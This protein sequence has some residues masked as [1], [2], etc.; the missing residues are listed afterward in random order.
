MPSQ[1]LPGLYVQCIKVCMT[2]QSCCPQASGTSQQQSHH[3]QSCRTVSVYRL[4]C[5]TVQGEVWPCCACRQTPWSVTHR[6]SL[7]HVTG[8]RYDKMYLLHCVH[9]LSSPWLPAWKRHPWWCWEEDTVF[10]LPGPPQSPAEQEPVSKQRKSRYYQRAQ[11]IEKDAYRLWTVCVN[12]Y[13]CCSEEYF[14]SN[15]R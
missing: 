4:L 12:V 3:S 9:L 15:V 14:L 13:L 2:A 6:F 1:G 7:F 10:P 8:P 5:R 11:Q